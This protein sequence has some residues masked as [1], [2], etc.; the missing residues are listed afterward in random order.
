MRK[1]ETLR[2]TLALGLFLALGL[3][4]GA[5]AQTRYPAKPVRIVITFAGGAAEIY[6]R[7]VGQ[8]LNEIWGQPVIIDPRPGANGILATEIVAR[9]APDGYTL[10]AGV[11]GTHTINPSFYRKLPY[12][13]VRDFAPISQIFL[14]PLIVVVHPSL[15]VKSMRELAAFARARPGQ[16]TFS[17]PG[18]GN[19]GHLAG[20]LFAIMAGVK[21][22]HVPYKGGAQ[23]LVALMS[24]E[25]SL[26]FSNAGNSVP[27]LKTGKFRAL[28]ITTRE[29]IAALRDLPTV[30]ESGFP[31]FEAGTW[32]GFFAPAGTPREIVNRIA[33]DVA[34]VVRRPDVR[35]HMASQGLVAVGNTPEQ[36][37]EAMKAETARYAKL[38]RQLGIRAD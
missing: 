5:H 18:T 38:I 25:V 13:A 30:A 6:A 35:E 22:T 31:G 34:Q 19:S 14:A 36:F 27:Y 37:G 12:D 7:V 20:E 15:P 26:L 24:G 8:R 4:A 21:L 28:A 23:A 29:R 9:A 10:L 17:S 3:A 32:T 1:R 11:D 2:V 33:R 16:L